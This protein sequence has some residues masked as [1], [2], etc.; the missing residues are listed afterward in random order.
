MRSRMA[1]LDLGR[2]FL[3]PG[4]ERQAR[5]GGLVEVGEAGVVEMDDLLA[6]APALADVGCHRLETNLRDAQV[7]EVGECARQVLE[8]LLIREHVLDSRA[9]L[10]RLDIIGRVEDFAVLLAPRIE[11]EHRPRRVGAI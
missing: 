11:H 10:H 4:Q 3:Q 1:Q 2:R 9:L 5:V 7:A 8:E 6:V